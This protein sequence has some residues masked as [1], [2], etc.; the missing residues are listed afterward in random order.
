MQGNIIDIYYFSGTGNTLLVVNEI[1]KALQQHGKEVNLY[2]ITDNDPSTINLK[3]VIGL[4]FPVAVFSTYPFVWDFI[5]KLPLTDG[6]EIFMLDSLAGFS[7][8]MVGPLK[9]A[10]NKKGYN[11][12]GA[13]EFIMPGNYG[14]AI[15]SPI[16]IKKKI[17]NMR[18]KAAKFTELLLSGKARW[19]RIPL[20]SDLV[21]L[22]SRSKKPWKSIGKNITIDKNLC[23]KCGV[24]A[25]LCPTK[26]IKMQDYPEKQDGCVACMRCVAFCPQNA[27]LYKGKQKRYNV[28]Q[29]E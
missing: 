18:A 16:K 5:N 14:K 19:H 23:N 6:T 28:S 2:K 11:T 9:K 12:I 25:K 26:C 29:Y 1:A 27:I 15:P 20:L 24:C 22:L 10:L 3:H 13:C 21:R 7:G 17:T 8:G 4:A